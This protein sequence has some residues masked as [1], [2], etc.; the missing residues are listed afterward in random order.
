MTTSLE[1]P[2]F[3]R[4]AEQSLLSAGG[5]NDSQPAHMADRLAG[6]NLDCG[7]HRFKSAEPGRL[8]LRWLIQT[9]L[10][11][12]IEERMRLLPQPTERLH[13]YLEGRINGQVIDRLAAPVEV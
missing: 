4:R 10:A 3:L 9:V 6:D 13:H 12:F 8:T 1:G 7:A 2:K 5:S 11:D